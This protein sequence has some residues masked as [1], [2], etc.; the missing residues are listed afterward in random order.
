MHRGAD[1]SL[2]TALTGPM[3]MW[4][5][6]WETNYLRAALLR[7]MNGTTRHYA[8]TFDSRAVIFRSDRTGTFALYKQA[9][10]QDVPEMIPTGPGNPMFPRVSPDGKWLLYPLLTGGKFR[11]MRVPLA[12]GAPQL[13]FDH[14]G[15]MNF[16][17][18]STPELRLRHF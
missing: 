17:L 15:D 18:S 6:W 12:G 1:C 5:G 8:W 7:R 14:M 9:L 2:K 16:R 11:L 13:V 3:S 4:A 10:D